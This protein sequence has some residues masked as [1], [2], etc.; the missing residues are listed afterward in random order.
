MLVVPV[1]NIKGEVIEEIGL[2][3]E[4]FAVPF[5]MA[6]VHQAMV[7]Q[8]A[9]ARSGTADTKTRAEVEGSGRKILPQKHTGRARQG[10]IRAPH[11]RGS[12]A[13][14]GPHPR[15]YSQDMPKKMRRLALKCLLSSKLKEGELIIVDSLT[16][17]QP[18]TKEMVKILNNL[19]GDSSV[20]L[21]T[22]EVEPDVVRAARNL[23]KVK[24][25]PAFSLNVLDLLTYRKVIMT[26]DAVKKVEEIW[27]GR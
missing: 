19:G 14:F 9:N 12:G 6:V 15:D 4:V 10:S 8:R 27:G 5:N 3:E 7:R 16:P 23:P 13:C 18:K 2:K 20:L 26:K 1:R 17:P 25:L 11:R 24:T 21:V 22:A